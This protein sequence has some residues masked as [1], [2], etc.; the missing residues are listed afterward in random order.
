MRVSSAVVL[1]I[2]EAANDLRGACATASSESSVVEL[3]EHEN[4]A[5]QHLRGRLLPGFD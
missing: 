1:L 5:E 3:P 4:V 2:H